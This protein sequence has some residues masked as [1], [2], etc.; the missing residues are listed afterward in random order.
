MV[1]SPDGQIFASASYDRTIK[2]WNVVTGKEIFTIRGRIPIVDIAFSP[3]GGTLAFSSMGIILWDIATGTNIVTFDSG[4]NSI[5]FSPDGN[6]L[7]CAS[8]YTAVVEVWDIEAGSAVELEH[9]RFPYSESFS[10]DSRILAAG[11]RNGT[12]KLWDVETGQNIGNLLGERESWVS[13]VVFSPDGRTIASRAS[14]ERFTRLWDI[15]TQTTT[16]KLEHRSVTALTFSPDGK[17]LAS[18]DSDGI[19][20]LWDVATMQNIATLDGHIDYIRCLAF[21]PDGK[22]LASGN[23][24]GTIKL[25]DVATMQNIATLDGHTGKYGVKSVMFLP[26]GKTLVSREFVLSPPELVKLWDLPT[27]KLITTFEMPSTV[28]NV[29]TDSSP[30]G[31]VILKNFRGTFSLWDTATLKLIATLEGFSSNGKTFVSRTHGVILLGDIEAIDRMVNAP[32]DFFLSVKETS[33]LI[34]IPLKVSAVNG[35]SK[36][37]KSVG[38]L[39]DALGMRNVQS[40]VT[41][42]P[43][44][45]Y[46]K[47]SDRG[48]PADKRL[49]DDMGIAV[50]MRDSATVAL[51]GDALGTNGRSTITLHPGENLVGIPL[52]DPRIQNMSDLFSL[53]GIR[54]NVTYIRA[55]D[56]GIYK[57]I[58]GADDPDDIPIT[59]GQA[60][61]LYARRESTV[62]ICGEKWTN[63]RPTT[64]APPIARASIKAIKSMETVLLSNFPNPFNP[65]TWIPFRLAED[66]NVMLTIYDVS[67]KEVRSFDIGH[68]K[69]GIYE[70]RDKAIYWDGE[71]DLGESVASGVYFYHLMTGEYSATKR[72]VILK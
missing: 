65:E 43:R 14:G 72:M 1:F 8:N 31:T 60:F 7:V 51:Q 20:K 68:S 17:I 71:N 48:T 6:R 69:A 13:M 39:Y 53:H 22:I 26:D 35:I 2:L 55:E 29:S 37:I 21:S 11:A 62:I 42:D 44:A 56:N 61:I 32:T 27:Q 47:A 9:T 66:A 59:G 12:I 10:P 40:I 70:S 5:A 63:E 3:N 64:A 38:D 67:G 30:D 24:D 49:T 15:V 41:W 23:S 58:T 46:S 18:G 50:N 19:I 28:N 33:S 34:H 45:S 57:T 52:K 16:A 36:T 4:G 25:W 54:D